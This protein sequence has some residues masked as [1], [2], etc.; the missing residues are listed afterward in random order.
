[1]TPQ[2]T[3]LAS[4]AQAGGDPAGRAVHITKPTFGLTP[5]GHEFVKRLQAHAHWAWLDAHTPDAEWAPEYD[6]ARC[7]EVQR[8]AHETWNGL[9]EAVRAIISAAERDGAL[10]HLGDLAAVV[11]NRDD[12]DH[13]QD[14]EDSQAA[15]LLTDALLSLG[16]VAPETVDDDAVHA[17]AGLAHQGECGHC[18]ACR[19]A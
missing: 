16:G 6:V 12:K 2:E 4:L 8:H 3:L 13:S 14:D 5:L 7:E 19:S 9:M 18:S 15:R 11:R 1:M 10:A 17:A